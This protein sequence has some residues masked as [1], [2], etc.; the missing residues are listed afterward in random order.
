MELAKIYPPRNITLIHNQRPFYSRITKIRDII[1]FEDY[2]NYYDHK[3]FYI[4]S[5]TIV[6]ELVNRN[7]DPF[8]YFEPD[9]LCRI[10]C[11]FDLMKYWHPSFKN[12]VNIIHFC[13]D[14]LVD[15]LSGPGG[16][17]VTNEN[18]TLTKFLVDKGCNQYNRS[19]EHFIDRSIIDDAKKEVLRCLIMHS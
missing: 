3:K 17:R 10:L 13:K 15:W 9:H 4:Y 11:Y 16:I 12:K 6:R 19:G 5:G 8:K 7:M 18:I 2:M 1:N 14:F